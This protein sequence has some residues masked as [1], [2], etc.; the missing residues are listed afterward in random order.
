MA[1]G[2]VEDITAH[3]ELEGQLRRASKME[4]LGRLAG[5]VAHDFNNLLTVVNGYADLLVD[6]L[7]DDERV[8]DAIEIRRAGSRATELTAQLLAFGRHGSLS[9]EPVDLNARISALVPMLRRLLGEDIEFEVRLDPEIGA[10]DADP[11]QLDQVVMN[12]VV[13]ARDAMLDGGS[14]K[15]TTSH[16]EALSQADIGHEANPTWARLEI[17]DSGVGIEPAVLDRIF[18]PFFT[19]KQKGRGTGLG[20][21]TV[22]SIVEQMAGR[23][24]VESAV[25]MGARFI[26]DLPPSLDAPASVSTTE[27]SH[28]ERGSETILLVENEQAVRDFCKRALAMEGYRVV[29]AG[30]NEAMDLAISLG[31]DLDLLVTDVVMPDLDGRTLAAAIT[32]N[33]SGLKVLFMSGYPRDLETDVSGQAAGG[34]LGKPFSARELSEAVRQV[35]DRPAGTAETPGDQ[36]R[37]RP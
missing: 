31:R 29:T 34:V 14:L 4:A 5:G 23:I 35:L 16:I 32:R 20:L 15:L 9:L 30:P 26:V 2:T 28:A 7:G 33:H 19:T 17:S 13:N 10:V 11:S 36:R 22:Y 24:R 27:A 25:G 37:V 21:A 6:A 8:V 1:V 12:L 18:E 3:K